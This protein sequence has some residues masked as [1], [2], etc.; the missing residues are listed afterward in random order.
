[1]FSYDAWLMKRQD[2]P[3]PESNLPPAF[4]LAQDELL[5]FQ[6]L[7]RQYS[8]LSKDPYIPD[9]PART[10]EMLALQAKVEVQETLFAET[11]AGIF[12]K[13][14]LQ[15]NYEIFKIDD[16]LEV[17]DFDDL[18]IA[19]EDHPDVEL[20]LSKIITN[21]GSNSR[22]FED[23]VA[24]FN[25]RL[26]HSSH[27]ASLLWGRIKTFLESLELH[28]VQL[29]P[30]L[31]SAVDLLLGGSLPQKDALEV[32]WLFDKFCHQDELL[33]LKPDLQLTNLGFD[34]PA[35]FVIVYN[36]DFSNAQ[37]LLRGIDRATVEIL[38]P[39]WEGDF[40]SL[41]EAAES[42]SADKS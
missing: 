1:M 10:P 2:L 16:L 22:N 41:L 6:E 19:I 33:W 8:N 26:H 34:A 3:F 14:L 27:C 18:V 35:R 13:E 32:A 40:L 39:S 17:L 31:S 9:V 21:V 12:I 30:A 20:I 25:Y 4:K 15:G 7:L 36:Y 11:F 23:I 29:S 24:N 37:I 38:A 42:L 28:E 5:K